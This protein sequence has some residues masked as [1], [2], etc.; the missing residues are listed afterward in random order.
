MHY[1]LQRSQSYS[2]SLSIIFLLTFIH[3]TATTTFNTTTTLTFARSYS[4]LFSEFNIQRSTDDKTVRLILNRLSG[5]GI[6]SSDYYN[7]GFFSAS[8]KM[9][10]KY[11]AGI[12]VAFYTSNVDTF[13]RNHDELDIEFLGNVEGKA[14]RFQT[15]VYGNGSVSRGR[16]ERYRMWFD[17]SKDSHRYSILWTPKN[18]IFYVDEIPIREVIRHPDM[19]G[20]YPSKP[21][22]V[23]ATIWDAS[24]WATNGGKKKVDYKYEPF[25]AEFKDLVL[26]GCIVDPNDQIPSSNCT[27]TIAGL[28]ARDYATISAQGR[29]SMR[30]FRQRHMYYSY[31]YDNV[32]YPVAPP[33]CVIVPWEKELFKNSGG[34]G[35]IK[36]GGRSSRRHSRHRSKRQ[37]MRR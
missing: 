36:F 25:I 27:D 23:Y 26:H 8:I 24:S 28:T 3:T 5:S 19:R 35:R 29:K 1:P 17:P 37:A 13:E 33:E 11:T 18:I 9:P 4:P 32:R 12:V 7:Y 30:W 10:S 6:I 2:L 22:S 16:E 14:W 20:D 21:M 34:R 31:C 15:N